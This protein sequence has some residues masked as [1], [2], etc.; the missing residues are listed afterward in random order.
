MSQSTRCRCTTWKSGVPAKTSL[1]H[2]SCGETHTVTVTDCCIRTPA[3]FSFFAVFAHSQVSNARGN[4]RTPEEPHN[5]GKEPS[6]RTH[7]F[8]YQNVYRVRAAATRGRTQR[9]LPGLVEVTILAVSPAARNTAGDGGDGVEP[10][11]KPVC[12]RGRRPEPAKPACGPGRKRGWGDTRV[13]CP[14]GDLYP[15]RG[16][17][18][19]PAHRKGKH[20]PRRRRRAMSP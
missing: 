8:G 1:V 20:G 2:E 5:V 12:F 10:T 15:E 18:H 14:T 4:A 6:C 3:G 13:P 19:C 11:Q 7:A 17:A 16:D 9:S